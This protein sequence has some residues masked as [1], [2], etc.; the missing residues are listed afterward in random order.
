MRKK[1]ARNKS[2][3]KNNKKK[4]DRKPIKSKSQYS[5]FVAEAGPGCFIAHYN[6]ESEKL[7]D[8]MIGWEDIDPEEFGC[9]VPDIGLDPED[10]SISICNVHDYAKVAYVTIFETRSKCTMIKS[11]ING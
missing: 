6:R 2:N 3:R 9:E 7:P 10:F 5:N 1:T 11:R 4:K 8:W